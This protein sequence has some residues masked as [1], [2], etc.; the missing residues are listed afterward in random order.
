MYEINWDHSIALVGRA[1][2]DLPPDVITCV[3]GEGGSVTDEWDAESWAD[4]KRAFKLRNETDG[5]GLSDEDKEWIEGWEEKHGEMD[6]DTFNTCDVDRIN[7]DLLNNLEYDMKHD[8]G[9]CDIWGT[10]SEFEDSDS[11]WS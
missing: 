4:L 5:K 1:E 6:E 7:E 9:F 3:S 2:E 10:D 11:D 8:K